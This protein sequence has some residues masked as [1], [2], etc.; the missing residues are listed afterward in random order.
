MDAARGYEREAI[1]SN[2]GVNKIDDPEVGWLINADFSITHVT[3]Y[4]HQRLVAFGE[5]QIAWL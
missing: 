4:Q 2:P 3:D 1:Q 5:L